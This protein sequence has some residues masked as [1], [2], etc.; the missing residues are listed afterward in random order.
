MRIDHLSLLELTQAPRRAAVLRAGLELGVFDG[1]AVG[2]ATAEEVA[3]RYD[4]APRGMRILLNALAAVGL[5]RASAGRYELDGD[6]ARLLARSSPDYFGESLLLTASSQEWTALGRLAEAVRHGGTVL[7]ENAE[8]PGYGFWPSLARTPTWH[9][10]PLA[11]VLA[12][13]VSGWSADRPQLDI[14]DVAC[15]HG[16]YGYTVAAA[17]PQATVRSLDWANV[18]AEAQ[19]HAKRLGVADR[20][21]FTPGD[22]FTAPLGGPYD[23]T[24][25]TNVLHHFAPDRATAMLRRLRA[26]TR[27]GGLLG[28]VV[29][30]TGEGD[31]ADDPVPHLFAAVML[32][33]TSGG[34][35]HSLDGYRAMFAEAGYGRPRVLAAP[36]GGPLRLLL[37]GT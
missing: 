15:G 21:E 25:I 9:T 19:V 31:P 1:L 27:P 6:A 35:S 5:V 11:D 7:A 34:E 32:T 17:C 37:A 8:T 36:E 4:A 12:G 26:V 20:V 18:L 29:I 30:P 16:L 24:L 2:P 10:Y 23:L 33:W 28:A 3:A 22:M 14:L 13:E